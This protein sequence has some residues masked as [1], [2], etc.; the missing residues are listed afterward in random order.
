MAAQD[1]NIVKKESPE[2][3]PSASARRNEIYRQISASL[4]D[5]Y[6]T[7]YYVDVDTGT[8]TEISSTDDYKKLNVPATGNDF[9][10]DS[11]RSIRRYVHPDD[12]EK[13]NR[14]HYKDTMLQNLEN[15]SSFSTAYRLVVDG[16]VRYIRNIEILTRDRKH[17]LICIENIDEEVKAQLARLNR[18]QKNVTFTQIAETLA[19]HY[20]L[21]YYV[22]CVTS[23]YAEL[24]AGRKSGEL[25]ILEE[26]EDFF[27]NA[28]LNADR[29]IHPEDRDRIKLFLDKDRFFSLLEDRRQ[30]IE[31]Y[32]MF[33]GPRKTQYTR[34]TVSFS[35]DRTH[36]II[37]V[38][39]REEE[40]RR[41]KEHL[42][43]LSTA[44]K[45]ARLDILT[46]TRNKTAYRETEK[47]L[48]QMIDGDGGAFGLV[49]CDIN[50]LKLVN[51]TEGHNAGD[52]CIKASCRLICRIFTH[53]PVFR[54]GGDEFVVVLK[55]QDY[56]NR[57]SLHAALKKR[58]QENNRIGERP[59]IASG[60][61]EYEPGIDRRVVDVFNRADA[62]MY[63]DKTELKEQK[64][65]QDSRSAMDQARMRIITEE[66]RMMLDSLFRSF[67][68]VSE[69]TYVFLCD[70]QY[71]YSRWSKNAVDTFGLPS[72][73]MYGAGDIWENHIHPEDREAYHK[74]IEEI[75]SGVSSDHDMQY[76][77]RRPDGQYEVCTCRGVV[78]RDVTGE[79]DYF[80]GSIRNHGLQG[81]VDTLTGLRNQY[82]FFEDLD[83]S[84]RRR[85]E[86]CVM[87]FG[88]SRFSQI[89]EM[90][91]YHFGNRVLQH[92]AR[93]VYEFVGNTG[94]VYRIDGTK[95]AVISHRLS[96][97]QTREGYENFRN[98]L[99]ENFQTDG[100]K[101]LL[102]LHCG[103]LTVDSFDI[104]PQTVYSCLNF[105]DD[106]SKHLRQGDLV[107][108]RNEPGNDSRQ[109]LEMLHEIRASIMRGCEGFHLLYQ[110]VVDA[111]TEKLIGAEAL[112][113][114]KSEKYGT[115]PPDLF[116]PI[117]ES[118]PLFP[119][120]GEWILRE[121]IAGS[122]KLRGQKP[123]FTVSVNLSYSQLE[124]P[125]FADRVLQL[126]KEQGCP[127][128]QVCLEVTERCRLLDLALLKNV[129]ARLKSSGIHIALDDFGT[130][131]SSVD[132]LRE[133]PF[134]AIKI[135]RSF[136]RDIE[137]NETDCRLLQS[138][139]GL[140]TLFGSRVCVE[141]VET[142]GMRDILRQFHAH[143]F[144]GYY[145]AKPLPLQELLQWQEPH[146]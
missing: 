137:K 29:L 16:R 84:I 41:E 3:D 109:S 31:D 50:D 65:L 116:I 38:E 90:Y 131:F 13:A 75:F 19:A 106:E 79:P 78:I 119:E 100:R 45:L 35:S 60:L 139:V 63:E 57:L 33:V 86:I 69:G 115:V 111:R 39:N 135:D 18:Q 145:Y 14:L 77:A 132:I 8:Y 22:D 61:A 59:V 81:Q 95:F 26:G 9:F 43:A 87:L 89:N 117:L 123:G 54:I 104:D 136:V 108:F 12:Q 67:E 1:A 99:H 46:G 133:V 101:V 21:I 113:R 83:D 47:T 126:L 125:D 146:P 140:G 98:Y 138:L 66:R 49:I 53:S 62:R 143:S 30:L 91:G 110:P 4:V 85:E 120:L 71:D 23:H 25:E 124:K 32:R 103:A 70:M 44:N 94:H 64:L 96:M 58:V 141:G 105:A 88:I 142:A 28:Q 27:V 93:T 34:M 48:Q 36:F 52:N 40:V 127:P 10:A 74:G 129:V 80:A 112:L 11:R 56:R 72:E 24:S 107:E 102:D 68:V 121:A 118:D 82:G 6:D 51:D 17:I 7:L 20:D 134:D 92:Y 55:G 128:A 144:Q 37:C 114:W 42:D 97:R 130:G 5:H 2:E 15:R 122:K 73:Y 76:R